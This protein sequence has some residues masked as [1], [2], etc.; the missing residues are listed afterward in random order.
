MKENILRKKKKASTLSTGDLQSYRLSNISFEVQ[1]DFL[2]VGPDP[3]RSVSLE[4]IPPATEEEEAAMAP[5]TPPPVPSRAHRSVSPEGVERFQGYLRVQRKGADSMWVR[6]WCVLEEHSVSCYIS[7]RD[8]TLT[9]MIPLLGSRVSEASVE[10]QRQYSFKVWHLESGQCLFFAADHQED[11]DRWFNMVI[12]GAECVLD[13]SATVPVVAF[14]YFSKSGVSSQGRPSPVQGSLPE[15]EDNSSVGS[16]QTEKSSGSQS[17]GL[18]HSGDLKKLSQSGKWKDRFVLI[19][20]CTLYVYGSSANKSPSFSIPLQG[21]SLELVGE[22]RGQVQPFSFRVVAL[23]GKPH[24][25][26]AA[27]ESEMFGWVT[28]VRDCSHALVVQEE[29]VPTE[30]ATLTRKS[31]FV[32]GSDGNNS[33]SQSPLQVGV[34]THMLHPYMACSGLQ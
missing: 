1:G 33:G 4:D 5:L 7:Q 12:K 27:N 10:C 14:F 11:F 13:E 24:T 19:R 26:A 17:S 16:S 3:R 22:R 29:Q 31:S 15:E 20:D 21:C 6:Y 30:S 34:A 8:I 25:F 23:A 18:Q 32:G 2:A 28:A 9:L